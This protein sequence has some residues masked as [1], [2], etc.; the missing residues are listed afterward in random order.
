M[1]K[2]KIEDI[3]IE[4]EKDGWKVISQEY[5]NLDTEMEFLCD[6]GHSVFASWKKIR[7]HRECPVCKLNHYK[8]QDQ[9]IMAKTKGTFRILALDQATR[10]SGFSVF[11]DKLLVKYGT[12]VTEL[13]DEIAR[14]A[15]VKQWLLSMLESWQIDLVAIEGIQYQQQM[16]VTTFET[17]ARL[18]GILMECLYEKGIPY[19]IAPTNTWR[20]HCGVKGKARAD[21]KK[22]MQLLVKKWF[23]VNVDNDCADAIGIGKYASDTCVPTTEI[24][25]WE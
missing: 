20:C 3:R 2:I 19:K 8:N 21:K 15:K 22:S 17:L 7:Q 6:E 23:D 9:K 12:F 1:S 25:N 4:V 10:V 16:G 18:Q 24:F 13:D 11:D 5:T 14:D